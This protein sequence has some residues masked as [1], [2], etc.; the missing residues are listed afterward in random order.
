MST[1]YPLPHHPPSTHLLVGEVVYLTSGKLDRNK[2]LSTYEIYK[3]IMKKEDIFQMFLIDTQIEAAA[4]RK[5][6]GELIKVSTYMI[7]YILSDV[8]YSEAQAVMQSIPMRGYNIRWEQTKNSSSYHHIFEDE[9]SIVPL[10]DLIILDGEQLYN[11]VTMD[12][13]SK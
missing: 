4:K 9:D 2:I 7:G 5:S 3:K 1:T 8:H 6:N 10:K 11:E 13:Q 12:G